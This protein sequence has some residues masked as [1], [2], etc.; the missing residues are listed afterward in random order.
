MGTKPQYV[1]TRGRAR[2]RPFHRP[3]LEATN[4]MRLLDFA[5]F[6]AQCDH[7]LR[8]RLDLYCRDCF[9]LVSKYL[10]ALKARDI[11]IQAD[12]LVID[13]A[14]VYYV[15]F[16]CLLFLRLSAE[17]PFVRRILW[18]LL[19]Y[20]RCRPNRLCL[21][22]SCLVRRSLECRVFLVHRM[23][24]IGDHNQPTGRRRLSGESVRRLSGE[25]PV[26]DAC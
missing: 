13:V 11:G 26:A 23:G 10:L 21:S 18:S 25:R 24:T 12:T 19:L 16:S 7:M 17:S 6:R 8:T 4:I 1:S 14:Q 5:W 15:I 2:G 3:A 20:C 9:D 22:Y